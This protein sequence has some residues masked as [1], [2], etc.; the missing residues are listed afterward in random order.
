MKRSSRETK[1]GFY[2]VLHEDIGLEKLKAE[3]KASGISSRT[4]YINKVVLLTLNTPIMFGQSSALAELESLLKFKETLPM[5]E[6]AAV[7]AAQK[8]D[9]DARLLGYLVELG[10]SKLR[11]MG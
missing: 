5:T 3:V 8:R 4:Q 1:V 10:L 7:A 9:V 11:D 6:I 2:L